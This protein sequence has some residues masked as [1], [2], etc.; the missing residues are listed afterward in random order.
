SNPQKYVHA[1]SIFSVLLEPSPARMGRSPGYRRT[2]IGA[3][4]VPVSVLL[5][6]PGYAPPR[7]QI[8][9]PGCTCTPPFPPASAVPT[10]HGR[11]GAR[12]PPRLP[13]E[14]G[15]Q[16]DASPVSPRHPPVPRYRGVR[17]NRKTLKSGPVTGAGE[18]AIPI[19]GGG[20]TA[21]IGRMIEPP[22]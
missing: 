3:A 6:V 10:S 1:P 2:T 4:E 8:V 5:K 12:R 14:G 18:L 9:S 20:G 16:A 7:T 17:A 13:A 22:L 11:R 15:H 19:G 21:V